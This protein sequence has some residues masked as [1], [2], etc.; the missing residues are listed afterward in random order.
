MDFV[1]KSVFS[2][3]WLIFLVSGMHAFTPTGFLPVKGSDPQ[4]PLSK[5][6]IPQM[7]PLQL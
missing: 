2:Q 4:P 3:L 6:T 1:V 7:Q 5:T